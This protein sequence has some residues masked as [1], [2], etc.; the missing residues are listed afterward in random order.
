MVS[1]R[2]RPVSRSRFETG[3]LGATRRTTMPSGLARRCAPTSTASPAGSHDDTRD[4]CENQQL[5][6]GMKHAGQ[7]L[8]QCRGGGEVQGAT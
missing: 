7:P 1:L 4:R 5:G 8:P 2:S 6:A 3:R